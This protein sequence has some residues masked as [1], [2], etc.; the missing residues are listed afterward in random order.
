MSQ[1]NKQ[2]SYGMN[3]TTATRKLDAEGARVGAGLGL[4]QYLTG[5][6]GQRTLDRVG[7]G[8]AAL[9]LLAPP[10]GIVFLGLILPTPPQGAV[11][12]P[13]DVHGLLLGA[14]ILVPLV[15][16]AFLMVT[17]PP[18]SEWVR[19]FV[20]Q[21]GIIQLSSRTPGRQ[22][23]RDADLATMTLQ[24]VQGYDDD[25]VACCA[26]GDH[27]GNKVTVTSRLVGSSGCELLAGH[28]ERVL[29]DRM[30]DPLIDRIDAG[31]PVTFGRLTVDRAGIS[32]GWTVPWRDVQLVSMRLHGHRVQVVT[33]REGSKQAALSAEP[34][35][36]LARY[37]IEY[38]AR[39]SGV[40]VSAE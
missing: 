16:A 20:Y 36:F 33:R 26:L 19:L 31:L 7:W 1:D 34:N 12:P 29:A 8:I 28:A 4:G 21:G 6:A 27:G 11:G 38:A 30:A 14:A 32:C 10:T 40:D 17:L 23:M 9:C 5:L 37:V 2:R 22:V 35:A 39:E 13:P 25:Y 24:V 3:M 18:R 15:A